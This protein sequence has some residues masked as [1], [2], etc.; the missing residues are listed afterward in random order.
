MNPGEGRWDAWTGRFVEAVVS[1]DC[2]RF[3]GKFHSQVILFQDGNS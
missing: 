3:H 1:P 2:D